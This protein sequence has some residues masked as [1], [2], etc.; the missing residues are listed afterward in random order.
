M[1]WLR[2]K[3]KKKKKNSCRVTLETYATEGVFM[4][5]TRQSFDPFQGLNW[6][7]WVLLKGGHRVLEAL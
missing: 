4:S 1:R 5:L 3:P 6:Y 2:Q 7:Q